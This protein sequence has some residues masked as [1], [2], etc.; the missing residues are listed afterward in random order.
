MSNTKIVWDN[1]TDGQEILFEI[2]EPHGPL[3]FYK[4]IVREK[5]VCDQ[6]HKTFHKEGR[7]FDDGYDP[8]GKRILPHRMEEL[9]MLNTQNKLQSIAAIA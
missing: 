9:R 5:V 4:G 1:L 3:R 6:I 8:V 2:F 7:Y